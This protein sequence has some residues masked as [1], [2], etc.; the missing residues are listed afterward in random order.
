[1][2]H[3]L[4]SDQR[5]RLDSIASDAARIVSRV[6]RLLDAPEA[7]HRLRED[8]AREIDGVAIDLARMTNNTNR[9]VNELNKKQ[10]VTFKLP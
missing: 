3:A 10:L 6:S 4:T 7:R 2:S 5:T 1:M 9:L 8:V